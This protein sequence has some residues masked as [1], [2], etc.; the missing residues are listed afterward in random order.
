M[1][2]ALETLEESLEDGDDGEI[3]RA[4]SRVENGSLTVYP[5]R[6]A[7]TVRYISG[8][9]SQ[10][11]TT[12]GEY[13]ESLESFRESRED[14]LQS[15]YEYLAAD[16]SRVDVMGLVGETLDRYD[17]LKRRSGTMSEVI[18]STDAPA[19]LTFDDPNDITVL[20]DESYTAELQLSN[21]G[22]RTAREVVFDSSPP[23]VTDVRSSIVDSIGSGEAVDVRVNLT[24]KDTGFW[25]VAVSASTDLT[26]DTAMFELAVFD[27]V[28]LISRAKRAVRKMIALYDR[29][30]SDGQGGSSVRRQ[31]EQIERRLQRA[32]VALERKAPRESI[33]GKLAAAI[34]QLR[35]V[36]NRLENDSVG[37]LD[38]LTLSELVGTVRVTI[39]SI[40]VIV[41]G[42]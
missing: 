36:S 38:P 42:T 20:V 6:A 19:I 4:I 1:I 29:G 8:P 22:S 21:V 28:T 13:V 39:D 3:L 30:S 18:E 2:Q 35:S 24:T 7:T 10:E 34:E 33:D 14:L 27:R 15:A 23:S 41:G 31:L 9:E 11:F 32:A 40:E 37:D 26:G 16:G 25:T 12:A 17:I 5:Q